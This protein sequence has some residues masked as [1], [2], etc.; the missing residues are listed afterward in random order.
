MVFQLSITGSILKE[1]LYE[2]NKLIQRS[3][4]ERDTT[5]EHL[6]VNTLKDLIIAKPALWKTVNDQ[7][8][9]LS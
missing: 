9:L 7:E 1:Y 3:V 5:V 8:M 4:V 6:W 2:H